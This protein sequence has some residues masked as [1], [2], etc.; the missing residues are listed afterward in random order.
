MIVIA[1]YDRTPALDTS[2]PV[3]TQANHMA[4]YATVSPI[5]NVRMLS[6]APDIGLPLF[7]PEASGPPSLFTTLLCDAPQV[8]ESPLA[9]WESCVMEGNTPARSITAA[10]AWHAATFAFGVFGVVAQLWIVATQTLTEDM[11]QLSD[12]IRLWN[13][14]SYFTI[15][16]NILVA[17]IAFYLARDPARSG[18][19]FNTLRFASVV[20]ISVTGLVYALVLAKVWEPT[21]WQKV[22][23]QTLHYSVPFL[24]VV[25]YLVFG[26]R[27]RFS[28]AILWR[29]LAIPLA[30]IV[31]TLIRSPFIT[32]TEDGETKHWY[33]Y[34]FIN[35]DDIG[36]G[37]ALVN[38]AAVFLLLLVV[39]WIYVFLDRKL[40]PRPT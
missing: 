20:M 39:S 14:L 32:Y 19:T 8:A 27:P 9:C 13:V 11:V 37:K 15:W 28:P 25:G 21:G 18:T 4:T 34:H 33:P 12:P 5:M 10:H 30:W 26:P 38:I 36:Y 35:I 3:A 29:S 7:M 23:D 6:A 22:A 24:A 16:S 1:T 40:S 2:A 31:Y 17:V